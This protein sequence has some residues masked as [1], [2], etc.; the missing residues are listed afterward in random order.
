M[1]IYNGMQPTLRVATFILLA[2]GLSESAVADSID[3]KAAHMGIP[4]STGTVKVGD[5]VN[6]WCSWQVNLVG[7][8]ELW[9]AAKLEQ[10]SVRLFVDGERVA[11]E[12]IM[13]QA[14]TK[15]TKK[16][17]GL[18]GTIHGT[19]KAR[20][21]GTSHVPHKAEI[22][23]DVNYQ[24]TIADHNMA[25]NEKRMYVSV[26]PPYSGVQGGGWAPAP[27]QQM[28][29]RVN[30]KAG[31]AQ[32]VKPDLMVL[33]ATATPDSNCQSAQ[34]ARV[35]VQVKNIGV[36]NFPA[37]PGNYMLFVQPGAGLNGGGV[38]LPPVDRNQTLQKAVVLSTLGSPAQ[39]AGK[40]VPLEVQL[41]KLKWVDEANHNNNTRKLM[42]NFPPTYCQ[43]PKRMLPG[44][45]QKPQLTLPGKI[46]Q[47]SLR[48]SR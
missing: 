20:H 4:Y 28:G 43:S 47:E 48:R 5:A 42:V 36:G 9:K 2:A 44:Q 37:S 11:S 35:I 13:I 45:L 32:T 40:S 16:N 1:E 18:D 22:T 29:Q 38:E 19:W 26:L 39:L 33:S 21:I 31:I 10:F 41:N 30:P 25:N 24:N 15:V 14:G 3:I 46:Q 8:H 27:P 17:L 6:F 7:D 12:V 34:S 23:C